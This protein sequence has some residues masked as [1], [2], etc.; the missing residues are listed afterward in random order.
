MKLDEAKRYH[1]INIKKAR[2]LL[3]VPLAFLLHPRSNAFLCAEEQAM[4][5]MLNEALKNVLLSLSP[6]LAI[7][8]CISLFYVVA[9]S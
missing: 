3:P 5:F 6:S 2:R 4:I 9:Q 8:Q 1:K 7:A